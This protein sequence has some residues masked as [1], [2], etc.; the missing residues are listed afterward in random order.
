MSRI[1]PRVAVS[2]IFFCLGIAFGTWASRLA[3]IKRNVHASNGVL[4]LTLS[5]VTVGSILSMVVVG[6]ALA[7]YGSRR[8]TMVGTA[9]M[10]CILPLL[11]RVHTAPALAALL[12]VYGVAIAWMD[13]SMNTQ[14]V[15]VEQL[16][17]RPLM[18]GFHAWFSVGG[19]AGAGISALVARA[20][21]PAP[22]FA[23]TALALAVVAAVVAPRMAHGDS[24]DSHGGLSI[25]RIPLALLPLAALIFCGLVGEGAA[26]SWSGVYLNET[27]HVAKQVVPAAFAAFSLMMAAGRFFGDAA[28][29]R[30]GSSALVCVSGIVAAIGL[31]MAVAWPVAGVVIVGF[32]L[33]G[34]GLAPVYPSVMSA[35]ANAGVVRA[36]EAVAL[37]G[38]VGWASFLISPPVVGGIATAYSLRIALGAIAVVVLLVAPLA[39]ALRGHRG[40]AAAIPADQLAA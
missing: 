8:M 5:A 38:M 21:A 20:L 2:A 9:G 26:E 37:M 32:G 40:E 27:V 25:Q 10:I 33:L 29:A 11:A 17:G 28:R 23:V 30:F 39:V 14:A 12:F 18:S 15:Y 3:E 19:L 34:L 16:A 6:G 36:G 1:T 35:A 4:G 24:D 22:H 7:R 31:G 13:V